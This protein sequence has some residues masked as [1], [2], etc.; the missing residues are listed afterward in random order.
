M[1]PIR[2]Q[3]PPRPGL[4]LVRPLVIPPNSEYHHCC[5]PTPRFRR[6]VFVFD[7]VSRTGKNRTND[8]ALNSHAFSVNDSHPSHPALVSFRNVVFD[9][10]SHLSRRYRM[11]IEYV[12]KLDR[13][14]F[15][16]RVLGVIG[17]VALEFFVISRRLGVMLLIQQPTN[18][19]PQKLERHAGII[20]AAEQGLKEGGSID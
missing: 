19:P 18:R 16:K 4:R 1:K 3:L 13:N 7:N 12:S 11:Q 15:G 5:A 14:D 20:C 6:R 9:N 2:D 17:L 10:R 8:L